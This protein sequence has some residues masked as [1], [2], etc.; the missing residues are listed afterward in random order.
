VEEQPEDAPEN[1]EVVVMKHNSQVII[2]LILVITI[3]TGCNQDLDNLGGVTTNE[4]IIQSKDFRVNS[5]STELETSVRGTVF[6]SGEEGVPKHAQIVAL[7]EIDPDDWGGV[8]FYIS[9]KWHIS[10]ITSSY[11]EDKKE[12]I[13]EDYASVWTT[14]EATK[15]GWNKMIEIGR[16]QHR[17]TPTGGG[18]GAVVIELDINKE[19]ISTSEVFS[20]TVGVG[21]KEKDGI[22]SVHP[23]YEL[24][25][26]PIP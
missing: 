11:P 7:V 20:M 2:I 6:L 17:W 15:H 4:K 14:P 22:R 16:D 25:E 12:K 10:S 3:I 24:I 18:K 23:D 8:V 13:P 9:D 5:D 19:T 26:I 21:S 1:Y